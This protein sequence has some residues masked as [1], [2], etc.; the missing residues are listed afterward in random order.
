MAVAESQSTS[1]MRAVLALS[2]AMRSST[3]HGGVHLGGLAVLATLRRS[4]PL[5]AAQLAA[6]QRLAPQSLTRLVDDLEKRGYVVRERGPADR[7]QVIVAPTEAG[8]VALS[9]SFRIRRKWLQQAMSAML[10]ASEQRQL[11]EA[12]ALLERLAHYQDAHDD[13]GD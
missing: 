9:T 2:R 12:A 1:L 6:E 3:P 10:N 8:L 11:L 5:P 4:G 13:P 7:R